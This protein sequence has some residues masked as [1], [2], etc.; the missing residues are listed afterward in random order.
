[1][2]E[3]IRLSLEMGLGGRLGLH[4]LPQAEAFYIR[5]R[6]TRVGLDPHYFD[7]AYFEHTGQNA[8]EW[9]GSIGE[10]P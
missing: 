10:F 7:L 8:T 6:M 1:M 2:A 3:A 5:C 4:S 9:L